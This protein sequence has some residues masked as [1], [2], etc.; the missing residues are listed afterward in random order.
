MLPY[1]PPLRWCLSLVPRYLFFPLFVGTPTTWIGIITPPLRMSLK[2]ITRLFSASPP[3]MVIPLPSSIVRTSRPFKLLILRRSF[4]PSLRSLHPFFGGATNLCILPS[5]PLHL[6]AAIQSLSSPTTLPRRRLRFLF[7]AM[8]PLRLWLAFGLRP[9][10]C[11]PRVWVHAPPHGPLLP[12]QIPM[13]SMPLF[14]SWGAWGVLASSDAL[15]LP[16]AILLINLPSD[17][18]FQLL[19]WPKTIANSTF[20]GLF[21]P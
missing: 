21:L 11:L 14:L 4:D 9:P 10:S 6:P 1:P 13:G 20:Q 18:V 3:T 19:L 16:S 12:A 5:P 2:G 8:T 7:A 17:L 15:L